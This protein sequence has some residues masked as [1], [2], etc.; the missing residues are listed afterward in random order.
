[1]EEWTGRDG[2][3][4]KTARVKLVTSA[5]SLISPDQ[6]LIAEEDLPF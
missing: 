4:M 2:N 3:N 5:Q 6:G 1:M